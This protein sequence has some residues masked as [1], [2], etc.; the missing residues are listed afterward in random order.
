M[1]RSQVQPVPPGTS[2]GRTPVIDALR[3][4]DHSG[5]I[6]RADTCGH[7]AASRAAASARDTPGSG[8]ASTRSHELPGPSSPTASG[9]TTVRVEA[10]RVRS[11]VAPTLAPVNP[12]GLTPTISAGAPLTT[13]V[14]PTIDG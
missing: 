5:L 8:R 3:V 9:W 14:R 11:A 2:R 10:G 7:A 1:V 13:S 12:R 4:A 6:A